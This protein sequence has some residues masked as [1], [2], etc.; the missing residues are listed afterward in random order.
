MDRFPADFNERNMVEKRVKAMREKQNLLLKRA[1]AAFYEVFN[2]NLQ[3]PSFV[4]TLP[5]LDEEHTQRL[6]AEIQARFPTM[7]GDMVVGGDDDD[8]DDDDSSSSS[9]EDQPFSIT[10]DMTRLDLMKR[11]KTE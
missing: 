8:D 6:L 11:R 2:G 3:Q 7:Y 1:R 10:M 9:E 4:F 5:E